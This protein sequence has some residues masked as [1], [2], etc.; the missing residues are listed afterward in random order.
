MSRQDT[1]LAWAFTGMLIVL[2]MSVYAGSVSGSFAFDDHFAITGN[3]ALRPSSPWRAIWET[4]FWGQDASSETSHKS[5]RPLTAASFRASYMLAAALL[6][7][8]P[9]SV[10]DPAWDAFAKSDDVAAHF[11][12]VNIVLHGMCTAVL[13]WLLRSVVLVPIGDVSMRSDV[14][15][16]SAALFAVHPVHV[17]AVAGIVGRAELLCALMYMG[18]MGVWM[19]WLVEAETPAR[20]AVAGMIFALAAAGAVLAKETGFTL[21]AVLIGYEALRATVRGALPRAACLRIAA[22]VAGGCVYMAVRL[23]ITV[24]FNLSNYRHLENPIAYERGS[25]LWA[26]IVL[27]AGEYGRLLVWPAVMCAD[28]S[29]NAIPLARSWADARVVAATVGLIVLACAGLEAGRRVVCHRSRPALAAALLLG[30]L[31]ATYL[32]ASN[33]L[34]FVGTMVGERLLYLPSA[35]CCG[36]AAWAAY[37]ALGGAGWRRQAGSRAAFFA[38]LGIAIA[39]GAGRT[40]SRGQDWMSEEALF[41]SAANEGKCAGSAK[42]QMHAGILARRSEDWDEALRRFKVALAIEPEYCANH[43]WLGVTYL[44]KDDLRMAVSELQ[45]AMTC[46]YVVHKTGPV[47]ISIYT[48]LVHEYPG[49]AVYYGDLA[50]IFVALNN[51]ERALQALETALALNPTLAPFHEL[52]VAIMERAGVGNADEARALQKRVSQL[53]A[54]ATDVTKAR[55]VVSRAPASERAALKQQLATLAALAMSSEQDVTGVLGRA[56]VLEIVGRKEG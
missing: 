12:T 10:D 33:V 9:S 30:W 42:V 8:A 38:L 26:N 32:P 15:L 11:R 46:K 4:D 52:R 37:A 28:Y 40:A 53:V 35:T 2:A 18:A 14:A 29:F 31:V 44:V 3:L 36:L 27:L 41:G 5:W 54:V 49:N 17:E 34:F 1:L 24:T 50:K 6:P 23:G 51:P 22:L 47:L 16:A 25:L 45:I 21:I 7:N 39:L 48:R 43:Y 13:F 20:Q 19:A 56:R 55:E